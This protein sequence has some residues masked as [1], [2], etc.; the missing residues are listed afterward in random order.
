MDWTRRLLLVAAV[1]TFAT[2]AVLATSV[3]PPVRTDP[4]PNATPQR[5]VPA[6]WV[7]V[8]LNVLLAA[9]AYGLSRVRSGTVTRRRAWA[10]VSGLVA[11]L[12]GLALMDAATALAGHGPAMRAAVVALW[13]CV[14]LDLAGGLLMIVAASMQRTKAGVG[15]VAV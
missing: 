12:L 8:I 15:A 7:N 13:V 2:A 14:C 4:F 9:E 3:I 6:F 1:A 11:L 5:A 10:G